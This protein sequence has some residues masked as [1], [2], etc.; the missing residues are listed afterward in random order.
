M[1]ALAFEEPHPSLSDRLGVFL[2]DFPVKEILLSVGYRS[3]YVLVGTVIT[4]QI[5]A[6]KRRVMLSEKEKKVILD[7]LSESIVTID[8][9]QLR[10]S[11]SVADKLKETIN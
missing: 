9:E 7:N 5:D 6:T 2:N 3:I 1:S 10:F 8:K 4:E 11:N